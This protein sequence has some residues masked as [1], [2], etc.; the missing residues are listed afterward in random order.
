MGYVGGEEEAKG[1]IIEYGSSRLQR[2][3]G[4]GYIINVRDGDGIGMPAWK[5]KL[6]NKKNVEEVG[7]KLA[8]SFHL[9][10]LG[11]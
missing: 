11:T 9:V 8:N 4:F 5:K 3:R 2:R 1:G 6:N 10:I 7:K